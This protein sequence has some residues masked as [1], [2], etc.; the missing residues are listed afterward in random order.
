MREGESNPAKDK[1]WRRFFKTIHT[2]M[3]LLVRGR[4]EETRESM[5][6]DLPG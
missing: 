3:A 4:G 5:K 6:L 1:I 2:G